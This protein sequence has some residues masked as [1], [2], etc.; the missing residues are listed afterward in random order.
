MCA[1]AH[2]E[3]ETPLPLTAMR[4][5]SHC[6]KTPPFQRKLLRLRA[7]G[8][9]MR[10]EWGWVILIALPTDRECFGFCYIFG[11]YDLNLDL[12]YIRVLCNERWLLRI[13]K[14]LVTLTMQEHPTAFS[15]LRETRQL[16]CS[17]LAKDTTD[18]DVH[19]DRSFPLQFLC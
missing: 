16:Q 4:V 2:H 13:R 6:R 9:F 11:G 14:M 17:T 1:H 19:L 18:V 15:L 3:R 7:G 10:I 12:D 8:P 5:S